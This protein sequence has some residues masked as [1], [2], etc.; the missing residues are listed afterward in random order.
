MD[1]EDDASDSGRMDYDGRPIN[2][3]FPESITVKPR[4]APQIQRL[5]VFSNN[6][7]DTSPKQFLSMSPETPRSPTRPNSS[8]PPSRANPVGI[9]KRNVNVENR[10]LIKLASVL[11]N[12]SDGFGRL[13]ES[14]ANLVKLNGDLD[15]VIQDIRQLEAAQNKF[16]FTLVDQLPG[17]NVVAHMEHGNIMYDTIIAELTSQATKKV[18]RIRRFYGSYLQRLRSD[19]NGELATLKLEIEQ[20][21]SQLHESSLRHPF[22]CL[23]VPPERPERATEG[24]ALPAM[25]GT[26]EG[27]SAAPTEPVNPG[28]SLHDYILQRLEQERKVRKRL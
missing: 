18:G 7:G 9:H 21:R 23:T 13:P 12:Q 19:H 8:K 27:E 26:V 2:V 6:N 15:A 11:P 5:P 10:V 14:R 17:D 22:D 1:G 24:P 20:L 28:K 16:S 4:T 3:R 25:L